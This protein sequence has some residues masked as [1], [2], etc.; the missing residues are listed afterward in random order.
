M[1]IETTR[2]DSHAKLVLR[3][4]FGTDEASEFLEQIEELLAA[5]TSRCLLYFRYV[6]YVNSTAL[7]A[8][9]RAQGRCQETGG[10]LA[11]A[12]PS[13]MSR[14]VIVQMGLD[15][16]LPLFDDEDKAIG[17]LSGKGGTQMQLTPSADDD[18]QHVSAMFSFADDRSALFPGKSHHGV[19]E[20]DRIDAKGI[21]FRWHPAERGSDLDTAAKMFSKGSAMHL[22][23]QVKLIRKEFF[24]VDTTIDDLQTEEDGSVLVSSSWSKIDPADREALERYASDLQF[25]REQVDKA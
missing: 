24:Q 13:A 2:A 20:V 16:I 25:L 22:K 17:F 18:A 3:G 9:V 21:V 8:V 19:G 23:M 10:A 15:S 14:E 5:G 11:I 1:K 6:K 4:E 7:G 12:R